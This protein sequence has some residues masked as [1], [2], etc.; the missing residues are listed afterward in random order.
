VVPDLPINYSPWVIH[1]DLFLFL[2][3]V[4]GLY[5][6]VGGEHYRVYIWRYL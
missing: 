1:R 5:L 4:T 6:L 2:A 3:L